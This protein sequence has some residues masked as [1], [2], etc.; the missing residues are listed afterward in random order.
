MELEP[1]ELPLYKAEDVAPV[2]TI[3]MSFLPG[4]RR[5]TPDEARRSNIDYAAS[6]LLEAFLRSLP[7]DP[8]CP[9]CA[10]KGWYDAEA[11][12][13]LRLGIGWRLCHCLAII[14]SLDG[15]TYSLGVELGRELDESASR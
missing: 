10:G 2:S 8:E 1:I 12:C 3:G 15:S 9:S 6:E 4:G 14:P 11:G 13:C 5:E 7:A